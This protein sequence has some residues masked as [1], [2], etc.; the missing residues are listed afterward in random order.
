MYIY[1]LKNIDA[2]LVKK[3]LEYMILHWL[4][5]NTDDIKIFHTNVE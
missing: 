1:V 2:P 3:A 5:F 4:H